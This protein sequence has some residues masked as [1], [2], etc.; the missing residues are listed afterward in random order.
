MSLISLEITIVPTKGI[1]SNKSGTIVFKLHDRSRLTEVANFIKPDLYGT[2]E[3]MI[4]YG[5]HHPDGGLII[6][7]GK[8]NPYGDLVNGM[9]CKDKFNIVNSS[10]S[11]SPNGEVDITVQIMAQ[12]AVTFDT[13][14]IS[15]NDS[16]LGNTMKEIEELQ[17]LIAR[18][19]NKL[20]PGGDNVKHTEIRGVQILEASQDATSHLALTPELKKSMREL[21]A[22]FGKTLTP[23]AKQLEDSLTKLFGAG[24]SSSKSKTQADGLVAEIK[25]SI[26]DDISE[27]IS[28]LSN[29]ADPFRPYGDS[30][31]K[32]NNKEKLVSRTLKNLVKFENEQKKNLQKLNLYSV[33]QNSGTV[34]LA[35]I[36]LFFIGQPLANS[37]QFDEVQIIFYPFNEWAGTACKLNI[38]N[39]V[40][41]LS[42]FTDQFYRYRT[43][44]I[45]KSG[46]MSLSQFLSFLIDTFLDDPAAACYGLNDDAGGF[47]QT[48]SKDGQIKTQQ[49]DEEPAFQERLNKKLKNV[50][51]GGVWKL[52]QVKFFIESLT[53]DTGSEDGKSLEST[54]G[55]TIVRVHVYD[56][57]SSNYSSIG[58]LIQSARE[59]D[60]TKIMLAGKDSDNDFI[61]KEVSDAQK[62]ANSTIITA[63]EQEGFL[64]RVNPESSDS[65]FILRGNS[66]QLK[67]FIQR[68]MPYIIYGAAGSTVTSAKLT[69]QQNPKLS[70]VMLLRSWS[71]GNT[72]PNGEDPGGLPMRIIPTQLDI[73]MLGC[74]LLNFAQSFYVD[75]QTGTSADNIYNVV[76]ITHNFSPG[77][78]TTDIK[79]APG[80]AYGTYT[81]LLDKIKDS[82][83][84]VKRYNSEHKND[85]S[86]PTPSDI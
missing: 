9:R 56:Q 84:I 7:D 10:F 13:Q 8:D 27:K 58:S 37:K 25:K 68:S 73:S 38:G 59:N 24:D 21:R 20:F 64:E 3:I 36:I 65:T 57:V 16:N 76:G 30:I 26:L 54:N 71:K 22:S 85:G 86:K 18:L 42:Y 60:I 48:V 32:E 19:R 35:N 75:F 34:S 47:F 28:K 15:S 6:G 63:A 77:T 33:V 51:P 66:R 23:D 11:F 5:W 67:N 17:N 31:V 61:G 12:G 50:T 40:I 46:S 1:M 70:T 81:S 43:E 83:D 69:S 4:E 29:A 55:K 62:L 52:P 49:V 82:M 80:D 44:H 53:E 45:S 74:P 78:Y 72:K 2:T 79:M 14:L 39:F 41:D